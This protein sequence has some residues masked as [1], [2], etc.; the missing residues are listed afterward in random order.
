LQRSNRNLHAQARHEKPR[1]GQTFK[2][3]EYMKETALSLDAVESFIAARHKT[4]SFPN[5][6]ER[7]LEHDTGHRR[8]QRLRAAT[9]TIV[10]IYNLFLI[11]DWLLVGDKIAIA[12]TLHFAV[13][14]PWILLTGLLTKDDSP[15]LVRE[16]LAASI[17]VAIVLQILVSFMLTSSPDAAHYQY[18]VLLVVLFTNTVQRLPFRY[19]VVVSGTILACHSLAVIFGGHMSWS[20]AFVTITTLAVSAYLTLISNYYLER[21]SRRAFLH[22]LR[23]RLRHLEVEA[24]SRHDPLTDLANRRYLTVRLTEL[25]QKGDLIS[26]VAMIMLDID[27]FKLFNDRYGHVSGDSC[28]KRVAACVS[29]ELRSPD[30]LAVRYGG[31]ELLVLLPNTDA[32]DAIR[33]AE[34]IRRSIE[35]IAIPHESMGASGIVTASC[36]VAAAPVST[37]SEQELIAAADAALYA[38]KRNGRN[39]VWPPLLRAQGVGETGAHG[40]LAA[41]HCR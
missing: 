31:E 20:V 36:G 30:D 28:L 38:A 7:Q 8:A 32:P 23:D 18:F 5:W 26:P 34:R 1:R 2:S 39:Q 40:N 19:A 3:R 24:A 17:P 29:A 33:V 12:V 15:K 9:P 10:I 35:A 21:D 41:L 14:T 27:N 11:P 16:G 25:W 37:I 13:V 22:A 4:L 6:L